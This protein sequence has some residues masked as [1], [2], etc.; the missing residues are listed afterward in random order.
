M[1]E[2]LLYILFIII[3]IILIIT[4]Y[5]KVK[6]KFW[7]NQP[8]FHAYDFHYYLF[9]PGI[10]THVLPE[11]NKY[12]NF[13]NIET[14]TYSINLSDLQIKKCVQ[15]I[16]FHYLKN[17][18]NTFLPEKENIVPY[19]EGH[20][21]QCFFTIYNKPEKLIDIKTNNIIEGNKIISLITSRPIH[22]VINNGNKN[23]TFDAYYID[24]LCV[25]KNERKNG[26][27]P[28]MIKTH[29][30]NSRH[31]N[32][33]INVNIFK[34]EGELTG[35]VPLCVYSTYGFNMKYWIKPQNLPSNIA[36]I[37]CGSTNIKY[38]LDFLKDNNT[39]FDICMT[40]E[41]SN[42]MELIKTKNIY[43]YMIIQEDEVIS[44]Y[45]FRK[46]NTFIEEG[47]ETTCCFSSINCCDDINIFTHGYKVALWKIVENSKTLNFSVIE[48]I[49]HNHLIIK[50]LKLKNI[51]SLI[52]P[53]AYFFYNFAYYTFKPEKVLIIN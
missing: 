23:A 29:E 16:R 19:F 9:P 41:T 37:E 39:K 32:K 12:C 20:N 10:I 21:S 48:D 49:S 4:L 6:F 30:Y 14:Y 44:A 28:Q 13:K 38:L 46:T 40:T 43:V 35:I 24:Y 47:V 26:I 34:R 50:N 52:S 3:L 7:C 17:K 1:Y 53:T 27:A 33:K 5:I 11:K 31:L 25:D 36:L 2:Y 42:L 15:F 18:E 22:V 45:F 8:V 51:P